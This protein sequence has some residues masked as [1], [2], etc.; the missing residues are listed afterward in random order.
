MI[1]FNVDKF[2][3][4]FFYDLIIEIMGKYSN[5]ILVD[6]NEKNIILDAIKHID[7]KKSS[8][9]EILPG[10]KYK[11]I[12]DEKKFDLRKIS[13]NEFV[14]LIEKNDATEKIFN[15]FGKLMATEINF[16]KKNDLDYKVIRKDILE[17][18]FINQVLFDKENNAKYLASVDLKSLADYKKESY[19]S[20]FDAIEKFYSDRIKNDYLKQIF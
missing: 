9:R 6:K 5:I 15:G 7:F 2:G 14:D 17:N 3:D 11:L 12:C 8:K 4:R 16:R 1:K 20:V 19:E 18:R 13:E 10:L